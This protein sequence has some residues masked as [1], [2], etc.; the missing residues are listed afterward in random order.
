MSADETRNAKLV[1]NVLMVQLLNVLNEENIQV[2][3]W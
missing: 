2:N 3:D 1:W